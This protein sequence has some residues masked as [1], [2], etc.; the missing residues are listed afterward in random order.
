MKSSIKKV[1]SV[2]SLGPGDPVFLSR[3]TE[4]RL[5]TAS[6][7]IIRT[8][9]HPIAE[10]LRN[11][12]ISFHSMDN[13]Y[14]ESDNFD[15]LNQN[16]AEHVWALAKDGKHPVYA[17]PD[18]LTDRTVDEVFR[19]C[20]DHMNVEVLP[21]FSYADFYLSRCRRFIS[22]GSVRI[23]SA[24]EFL[25]S[26]Y[27]PD[28]TVLVTE[29]DSPILAGEIKDF[30]S[31]RLDDETVV[32]LMY[33]SGVPRAHPLYE[34]DRGKRYDHLT[35]LLLPSV[36]YLHRSRFTMQDL[37]R[38]MDR[39]RAPDG[40]PWDRTQ[41]HESLQPYMVEEAWESIIAMDEKDPDHMADELGDLLFQ[42]VFHASIG[43]SFDEFTMDDVISHICDKMI[44]R[45]PHV[46]GNMHADTPQEVSD[47]WET[48]KRA[49]TGSKTVAES[50]NDVS[51]AFPALKYA[52]KVNKKALQ[53]P[54]YRE[55][56]AMVAA[57]IHG[58]SAR[59]MNQDGSFSDAAMGDLLF[60]C[61]LLCHLCGYDA[62]IILHKT[63]DRFKER[64]AAM[65]KDLLSEGK[66]P[67]SLTFSDLRVYLDHTEEGN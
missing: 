60:L 32:Y 5:C 15:D 29:I 9:R 12:G 62:E 11:K 26:F 57:R 22:E 42:I 2:L 14:A 43:K 58:I 34:L 8:D 18:P 63:V 51:P 46:F 16:V 17:V 13:I 30:L 47:R 39:L 53:L 10:W 19:L 40:C 45:H 54:A 50:L 37:L 7:L 38:I 35:A 6:P 66:L 27:Y 3:M 67:E 20:P 44:H 24:I 64:F 52:I 4:D 23:V 33:E 59:L 48:I 41:T 49:E 21:G 55:D 1:L 28:E 65:E 56:P 36:D 31:A 25:S 61:S